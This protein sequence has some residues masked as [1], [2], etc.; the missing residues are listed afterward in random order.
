MDRPV[1]VGMSQGARLAIH[2]ALEHP[3]RTR[4][5]VLDGA[6]AL[7]A[8]SGAAAGTIS[9]PAGGHTDLQRYRQRYCCIR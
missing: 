3:Q 6:P 1:L 9:Q 4:A 5:L 8:E 2:F 7:E